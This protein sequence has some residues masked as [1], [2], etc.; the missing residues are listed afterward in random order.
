MDEESFNRAFFIDPTRWLF[1]VLIFF[2]VSGFFTF[3]GQ[4]ADNTAGNRSLDSNGDQ[5]VSATET[6]MTWPRGKRAERLFHPIIVQVASRYEVD[7]ALIK[8][9]IMAESSYNPQAISKKGAQGLMQLMPRT[10][11]A[12]GVEDSFNPEHNINGGVRYFKKLLKQFNGDV[13]LALAAYNA[14]SRRVRQYQ[15]VPPIKATR[16]YINKV[17]EYYQYYKDEIAVGAEKA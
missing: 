11:R 7:P 17:F 16:Y 5:I 12:M 1:A 2:L 8:A 10:A 3:E 9:I 15:G 13:E 14:G 6:R 4:I